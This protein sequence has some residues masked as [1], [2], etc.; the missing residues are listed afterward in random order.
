[1]C[2]HKVLCKSLWAEEDAKT[3]RERLVFL[4]STLHFFFYL[5]L[6][7]IHCRSTYVYNCRSSLSPLSTIIII[8]S[9]EQIVQKTR[10]DSYSA[11]PS[12][13]SPDFETFC[14][15][16]LLCPSISCRYKSYNP[17]CLITTTAKNASESKNLAT[18]I[19]L[20]TW[21]SFLIFNG[22]ETRRRRRRLHFASYF[23][24]FLEYVQQT[25]V[26]LRKYLW[27]CYITWMTTTSQWKNVSFVLWE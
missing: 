27:V 20:L 3:N 24:A 4:L 12:I 14:V 26:S 22:R 5:R 17:R 25:K 1:M 21:N 7:S 18:T 13:Q 6:L 19:V 2:R 10:R 9:I 8:H 16:T 15:A 11:I 23:S